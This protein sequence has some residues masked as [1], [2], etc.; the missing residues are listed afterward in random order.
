MEG[1]CRILRTS[2][3]P[4]PKKPATFNELNI[5]KLQNYFSKHSVL[6]KEVMFFPQE[7]YFSISQVSFCHRILCLCQLFSIFV[8]SAWLQGK[9]GKESFVSFFLLSPTTNSYLEMLTESCCYQLNSDSVK[10]GRAI[11]FHFNLIL[12]SSKP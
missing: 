7:I 1:R 12:W 4:R 8:V 6:S 3:S 2:I 11:T 9:Y 10:T 5:L